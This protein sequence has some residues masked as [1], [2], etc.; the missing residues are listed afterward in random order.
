MYNIV[1]I[2]DDLQLATQLK[3]ALA[4][5]NYNVILADDFKNIDQFILEHNP[6]LVILD[7]NLPYHDGFYWCQKIRQQSNVPILFMSSRDEN[8]DQVMALSMGGD[9]YIIKPIDIDLAVIKIQALLRRSYDY[10][11]THNSNLLK[12][13]N[14]VLDINKM[15]VSSDD[16]NFELTKNEFKILQK[17]MLHKDEY[18]SR[19]DLM[20]Y[21]WDND[22]F[23]DDNAFNTNMSR[24][25]K[26]L[27]TNFQHDFII[28]KRS[29]GYKIEE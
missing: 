22:S 19:Q 21:L 24:L 16:Q 26:K 12:T 15:V 10:E 2:E 5:F 23:I 18:V 4:K 14:L 8:L 7:I 20:E 29:V 11:L 27:D 3:E 9:D 13:S 1:C 17:L 25:R 6:H 28:N